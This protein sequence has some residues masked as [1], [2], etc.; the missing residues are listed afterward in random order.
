M[1]NEKIF[2]SIQKAQNFIVTYCQGCL[3][4]KEDPN[5]IFYQK[6]TNLTLMLQNNAMQ[7]LNGRKSQFFIKDKKQTLEQINELL[8]KMCNIISKPIH[9]TEMEKSIKKLIQDSLFNLNEFFISNP[10]DN[11][12]NAKLKN[13]LDGSYSFLS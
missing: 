9:S 10:S 4:D 6:L 11:E 8:I 13:I 5:Q 7:I 3:Y 1:S 12:E 2:Q